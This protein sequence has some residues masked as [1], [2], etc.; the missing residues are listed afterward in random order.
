MIGPANLP[1]PILDRMR[2]AVLDALTSDIVK[3][4][5][6]ALGL[7]PAP[8]VGADFQKLVAGEAAR[9]KT[10]AKDNNISISEN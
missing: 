1:Q 9:W 6:A 3:K 5:L 7:A 10:I 8:L 4:R 2:T